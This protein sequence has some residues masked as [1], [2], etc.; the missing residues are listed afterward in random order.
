[1]KQENGPSSQDEEEE[2]GLFLVGARP[3]VFL[4]SADGDVRELLEV[5]QGCQGPFQGSGG[6][7]GFLSRHDSGKGPQIALRGESPGFSQ[8]A[9][10]FP[11]IK[12]RT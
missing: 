11:S 6:K 3:K 1:M 10:G 4:S 2:P 12:M 9:V 7:V 8:V 5:P